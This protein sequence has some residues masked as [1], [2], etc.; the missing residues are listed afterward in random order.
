MD[1]LERQRELFER[2][3][4]DASR[5][6]IMSAENFDDLN[7]S[8]SKYT[9]SLNALDKFTNTY[10]RQIKQIGRDFDQNKG[11]M[12]AFSGITDLAGDALGE[13]GVAGRLAGKALSAIAGMTF[14]EVDRTMENFQ[15]MGSVGAVGAEGMTEFR[16]GAHA[17][18]LTMDQFANIIGKNA[19]ALAL[20]TGNT[21]DGARA[22]SQVT[23]AAGDT[24]LRRQ[25]MNLGV[26]I[27]EQTDFFA[28]YFAQI[29]RL[30]LQQNR[31]Y[32]SQTGAVGTY[33]KQLILLSRLT[34]D[35]IEGAKAQM[36]AQQR[37][38]R[39]S[40]AMQELAATQG[41]EYANRVGV[42]VAAIANKLGPAGDGLRDAFAG[43]N[44]QAA[45]DF[46]VTF[47][48]EGIAAIELVKSGAANLGDL[49][50][51]LVRAGERQRERFGGPGRLGLLAETGPFDSVAQ[52]LL[53]IPRAAELTREALQKQV[54][55][56]NAGAA[57]ADEMTKRLNQ[58]AESSQDAAVNLESA[59][60]IFVKLGSTVLPVFSGAIEGA[61][62][63]LK[64]LVH[65]VGGGLKIDGEK[66]AGGP[67]KAGGTY[68]VGEEGPELFSSK[69][70]GFI[71]DTSKTREYIASRQ[72]Y[73]KQGIKQLFSDPHLIRDSL[74]TALGESFSVVAGPTLMGDMGGSAGDFGTEMRPSVKVSG[75]EGSSYYDIEGNFIKHVMPTLVE[76]L[77]NTIHAGGGQT[78]GY[79]TGGLNV[80]KHFDPTGELVSRNLDYA[81]AGMKMMTQTD[82]GTAGPRTSYKTAISAGEGTN[83]ADIGVAS[84][85]LPD[86]AHKDNSGFEGKVIQE[87]FQ[88]MVNKMAAIE[89]N[90][91]T[92]ADTSKQLLRASAG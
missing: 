82:Y 21:L 84:G 54:D 8:T 3:M 70:S 62:D 80:Q 26:G 29:R 55:A 89:A 45:K 65:G 42:E 52:S 10:G 27:E 20:A 71:T 67:V 50:E 15:K 2:A 59:R 90:T 43:F 33:V 85:F 58:A 75:A 46:A 36:E 23:K 88:Q 30:G 69:Q 57:G 41:A 72:E 92:G 31:D 14:E 5:N 39:F 12:S 7:K 1:E 78:A 91:K 11:K 76:G 17:A 19:S 48:N 73:V 24:G 81:A 61:T 60:D 53:N 18:R 44:T 77:T 16:V 63:M 13:L 32:R 64:D 83:P 37:S 66:A 74:E 25:L 79:R 4:E 35:S 34:G 56:I 47:G 9:K 22:L 49:S 6:V 68:L 40:G 51:M 38:A 87:L 86:S 28:D